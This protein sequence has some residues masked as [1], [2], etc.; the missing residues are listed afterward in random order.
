MIGQTAMYQMA[1]SFW[2]MS[3]QTSE[4]RALMNE[5]NSSEYPTPS[6]GVYQAGMLIFGLNKLSSCINTE[7]FSFMIIIVQYDPVV[8][9]CLG[10]M[11][12]IKCTEI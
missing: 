10:E 3:S 2:S 7:V 8:F 1:N 5:A 9:S 4:S 6:G 11:L 12:V